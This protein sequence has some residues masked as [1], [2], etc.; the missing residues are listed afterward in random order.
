METK[1][2]K[3]LIKSSNYLFNV[4]KFNSGFQYLLYI[5]E[6]YRNILNKGEN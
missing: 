3:I 4:F 2:F 1:I 5:F 6:N